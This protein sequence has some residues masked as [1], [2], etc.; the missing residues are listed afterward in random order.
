MVF[1]TRGLRGDVANF[2]Q[3]SVTFIDVLICSSCVHYDS[4]GVIVAQVN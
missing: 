2:M 1:M 4:L 3:L